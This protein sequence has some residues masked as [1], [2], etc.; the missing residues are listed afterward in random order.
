MSAAPKC[1]IY[2]C[3]EPPTTQLKAK[4][5]APRE[6]PDNLWSFCDSHAAEYEAKGYMPV[7]GQAQMAMQS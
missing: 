7:G 4:P 6:N 2:G 1:S 3:P 5:P